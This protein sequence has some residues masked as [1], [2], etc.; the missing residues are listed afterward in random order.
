MGG[1]DEVELRVGCLTQRQS[2]QEAL[3]VPS[4]KLRSQLDDVQLLPGDTLRQAHRVELRLGWH[5]HLGWRRDAEWRGV[6][7]LLI[8]AI[9]RVGWELLAVLAVRG[10]GGVGGGRLG[11]DL[12]DAVLVVGVVGVGGL[13]EVE[14]GVALVEGDD[15]ALELGPV[16]G[17]EGGRLLDDDADVGR[18]VDDADGARVRGHRRRGLGL[19]GGGDGGRRENN[20]KLLL[21]V[22]VAVRR[23]EE[24][25]GGHRGGSH[26]VGNGGGGGLGFQRPEGV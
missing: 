16:L 18:R 25:H 10:G 19:G 13:Q 8:R 17:D 11:G 23:G 3:T 22:A 15:A 20:L 14:L 5:Q 1:A 9:G 4:H 21:V 7:G 26:V 12:G 24:G 6:V 2:S